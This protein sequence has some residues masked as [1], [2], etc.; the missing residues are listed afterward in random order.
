MVAFDNIKLIECFPE[1]DPINTCT[2]FQ[3]RCSQTN[4]CINN[5]R[6]CDITKDCKYG[7]DETQNCGRY[8]SRCYSKTVFSQFFNCFQTKYLMEPD[9]ILSKTGVDGRMLKAKHYSGLDTMDQHQLIEL[10]PILITLI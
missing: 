1:S 2:P 6:I 10:V 4:V 5:T 7:D 9:A 3:Y 8:L